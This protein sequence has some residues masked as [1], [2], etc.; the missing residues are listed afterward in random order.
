MSDRRVFTEEFKREAV[1][2]AKESG[3]LSG[4]ARNLGLH[5]TVLQR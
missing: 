3:N 4:T 2:L 1:R 5:P